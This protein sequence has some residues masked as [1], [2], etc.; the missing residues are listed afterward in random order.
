MPVGFSAL[1]IC[2]SNVSNILAL[3]EDMAGKKIEEHLQRQSWE[4]AGAPQ[5]RRIS[6]EF[7]TKRPR[8]SRFWETGSRAASTI[9]G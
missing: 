6:N 1:S 5:L 8:P 4:E 2:F 9:H 3:F 7:E